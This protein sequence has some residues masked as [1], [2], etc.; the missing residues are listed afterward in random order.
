MIE[1]KSLDRSHASDIYRFYRFRLGEKSRKMFAPYPLFHTAINSE[2]DIYQRIREWQKERTW[3]MFGLYLRENIVSLGI[4]KRMGT[5]DCTSA[6]VT[7]DDFNGLGFGSIVQQFIVLQARLS[8]VKQFHVKIVSDNKSSIRIHEKC[9][10]KF[11]E[12]V[13]NHNYG[14]L[15]KYIGGG[16][17]KIIRMDLTL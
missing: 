12:V 8:G 1:I 11:T 2:S 5:P 14:E 10:F 15:L 13:E 6:V 7:G 17:R 9:G 16:D 3:F 4:L